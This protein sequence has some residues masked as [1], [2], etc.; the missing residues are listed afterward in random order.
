MACPFKDFEDD[1]VFNGEAEEKKHRPEEDV[2]T[3]PRRDDY[4]DSRGPVFF[5]CLGDK[6]GVRGAYAEIDKIESAHEGEKYR[7]YPV[8]GDADLHDDEGDDEQIGR[9][10]EGAAAQIEEGVFYDDPECAF[11]GVLTFCEVT[12]HI[13]DDRRWSVKEMP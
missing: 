3:Q 8:V 9:D 5:L 1:K 10:E 11:H 12:T 2:E 6:A 7:P 13:L 4:V